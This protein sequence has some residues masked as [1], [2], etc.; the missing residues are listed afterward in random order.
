MKELE[1]GQTEIKMRQASPCRY[2]GSIHPPRRCPVYGKKCDKCGKVNHISAV[3]RDPRQAV[4]NIEEH[5]DEQT[6]KVN[7]DH[8]ICNA[9]RSSIA[10][11]LKTSS[12]YSSIN[13][14]YELD[15][16]SNSNRLPF[17]IFKIIFPKSANK[18][19]RQLKTCKLKMIHNEKQKF[20]SFCSARWQSS[21][22][23]HARHR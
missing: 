9:K 18:G 10:T 3:C 7:T 5:E 17:C 15:T 6:N 2:C 4:H 20:V 12:L 8:I 23:R 21:S 14:L 1:A 13:I 11:E 19:E 16:G 22:A